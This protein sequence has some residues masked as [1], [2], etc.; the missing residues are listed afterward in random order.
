MRGLLE[1]DWGKEGGAEC[2]GNKG[3]EFRMD[4]LVDEEGSIFVGGE[5]REVEVGGKDDFIGGV[6]VVAV[7]GVSVEVASACTKH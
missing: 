3:F 6:R 1:L 7:V 4:M 5:V 2:G